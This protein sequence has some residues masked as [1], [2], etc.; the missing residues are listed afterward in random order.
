MEDFGLSPLHF[1]V[2]NNDI[3]KIKELLAE[4]ADPNIKDVNG[5]SPFILAIQQKNLEIFTIFSQHGFMPKLM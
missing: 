3:I 2:V 4:G 1:A 5:V